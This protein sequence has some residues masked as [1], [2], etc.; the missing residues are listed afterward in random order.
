M[1]IAPAASSTSEATTATPPGSEGWLARLN[2]FRAMADLDPVTDDT[3][4]AAGEVMHA[5]YL[6]RNPPAR[7]RAQHAPRKLEEPTVHDSGLRRRPHPRRDCTEP[8]RV[9]RTASDRYADRRSVS[10]LPMLNPALKQVGLA[11]MARTVR[12][13]LQCKSATR[14]PSTVLWCR[15]HI[16]CPLA[17]KARPFQRPSAAA[18]GR[19]PAAKFDFSSGRVH[20]RRMAPIR[21]QRA[22]TITRQPDC[23]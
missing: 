21:S 8:R 1:G 22:R 14:P 2:Y 23:R 12:A 10:S 13:R 6:V 16:D 15:H 3:K 4:T 5:R 9:E 18:S 20:E 19:I 11:P 17:T 7:I